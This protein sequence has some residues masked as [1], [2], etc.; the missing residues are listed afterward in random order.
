MNYK[1]II[2]TLTTLF[3]ISC[4]HL[5]YK[6]LIPAAKYGHL[7][8]VRYHINKNPER[9]KERDKKGESLLF[10]AAKSGNLD[11]V[12]FLVEKG[13]DIN[14]ADR[15]GR[16]ALMA[17]SA[18]GHYH[19]VRY[20][21]NHKASVNMAKK[22]GWNALMFAIQYKHGLIKEYLKENG[23]T[24]PK[25]IRGSNKARFIYYAEIGDLD[26]VK[27]LLKRGVNV[28]AFYVNTRN[29]ALMKASEMGHKSIVR[30]LIKKGANRNM[31]NREGKSALML[32]KENGH[33]SI[34]RILM[35]R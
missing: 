32:A 14:F 26:K 23:A 24:A 35:R 16:T 31:K 25:W 30:F 29:T 20:L 28:N 27:D 19:I 17:A 22:D 11:V 1:L 9:V 7:D 15:E 18:M 12:K 13:A 8:S 2:F 6:D 4:T 34:A 10:L 3:F 33:K 21:V 5:L